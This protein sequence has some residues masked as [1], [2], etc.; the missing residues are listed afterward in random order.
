MID[1]SDVPL[2]LRRA[3]L[4]A[5]EGADV[6]DGHLSLELVDERR[7]RELNRAYRGRDEPTDDFGVDDDLPV[8]L[9]LKLTDESGRLH[10]A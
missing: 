2:E 6:R 1:A 9:I 8:Q 4:A 7:I 10:A 5:L 3:V